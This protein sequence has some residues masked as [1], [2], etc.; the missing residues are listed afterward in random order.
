MVAATFLCAA[1]AGGPATRPEAVSPQDRADILATI[2]RML[3][4]MRTRDTALLGSAFHADARLF[5]IRTRQDGGD[6]TQVLTAAQFGAF[7]A[8]DQR[9]PW[10]ERI[11]DPDVRVEGTLATVWTAY[12][13]HFG[14]TF[15]HCGVDAFQLLRTPAGWRIVS[16]ADTFQ[17]DGCTRRPL[18]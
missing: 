18:P 17:R 11:F 9:A 14:A 15:S 4:G 7:V 13:F 8:R 6:V 16:I 2:Q 10:H 5:G 12:D 1:C 3:D